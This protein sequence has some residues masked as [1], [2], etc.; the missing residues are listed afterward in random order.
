MIDNK[1]KILCKISKH[2]TEINWLLSKSMEE[3]D[4]LAQILALL[5]ISDRIQEYV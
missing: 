3:I 1:F 5:V 2:K 4:A